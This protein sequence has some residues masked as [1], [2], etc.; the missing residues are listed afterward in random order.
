MD[1]KLY[2]TNNLVL[3]DW[4]NECYDVVWQRG[5]E[6][7]L[8]PGKVFICAANKSIAEAKASVH[9]YDDISFC[10]SFFNRDNINNL[11][12]NQLKD[13]VDDFLIRFFKLRLFL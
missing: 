12:I 8:V 13:Y 3:C 2:L 11:N 9:F 4:S 6:N 10:S 1:G 5:K 7:E